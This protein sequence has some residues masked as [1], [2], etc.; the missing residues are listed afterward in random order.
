MA[1]MRSVMLGSRASTLRPKIR[2]KGAAMTLEL[3]QHVK[4]LDLWIVAE[5]R[6]ERVRKFIDERGRDR[7]ALKVDHPDP[8]IVSAIASLAPQ[9]AISDLFLDR[10]LQIAEDA[11]DTSRRA[12]FENAA[13]FWLAD[14]G[15]PKEAE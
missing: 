6:A 13:A 10:A 9:V 1:A 8:T 15:P 4:M 2:A 5:S 14:F 12:F 11:A 3:N 7:L